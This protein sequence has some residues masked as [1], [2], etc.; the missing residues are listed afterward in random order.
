MMASSLGKLGEWRR[1]SDEFGDVEALSTASSDVGD[2][3]ASTVPI[4]HIRDSG[5]E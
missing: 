5:D 1:V 3:R 4:V 2:R